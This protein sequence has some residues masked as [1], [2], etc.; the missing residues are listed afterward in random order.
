M[1]AKFAYTLVMV[2]M[3]VFQVLLYGGIFLMVDEFR[4][5]KNPREVVLG[6]FLFAAL[7]VSLMR[8]VWLPLDHRFLDFSNILHL[9]THYGV[10]TVASLGCQYL[11]VRL[12]RAWHKHFRPTHGK[13]VNPNL[14]STSTAQNNDRISQT[15][16]SQNKRYQRLIWIFTCLTMLCGVF[17]KKYGPQATWLGLSFADWGLFIFIA[18]LVVCY[19]SVRNTYTHSEKEFEGD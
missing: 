17:F 19:L 8:P 6:S 5:V 12:L 4:G 18:I 14:N 15:T 2:F 11:A 16:E 7:N 1:N 3:F 13:E 9:S 10:A